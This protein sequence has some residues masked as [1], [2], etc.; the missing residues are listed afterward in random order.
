MVY[1]M[2]HPLLSIYSLERS[3]NFFG[4][5]V[6]V[7]SIT[8]SYT[9]SIIATAMISSIVTTATFTTVSI[10]IICEIIA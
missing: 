7:V 10:I 6:I 5:N 1:H 9:T 4:W 8:T 2:N 3:F